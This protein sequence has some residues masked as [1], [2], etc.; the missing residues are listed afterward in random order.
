MAAVALHSIRRGQ[1]AKNSRR[2]AVG[3]RDEGNR[4]TQGVRRPVS[5]RNNPR[6]WTGVWTCQ[7][8]GTYR[9][10]LRR[11]LGRVMSLSGWRAGG[12]GQREKKE[13]S[14]CESR[15]FLI[16]VVSV[17]YPGEPAGMAGNPTILRASEPGRRTPPRMGARQ[18]REETQD[19][20]RCQRQP[21]ATL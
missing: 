19:T 3:R 14:G 1:A 9:R 16:Q 7:W 8:S 2:D 21:H 6:V 18:E 5:S 11:S 17:C 10:P 4:C 13:R 20:V 15:Q 12:W